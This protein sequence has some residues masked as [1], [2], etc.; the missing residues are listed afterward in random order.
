MHNNGFAFYL[1]GK[2]WD[3]M[4][5]FWIEN[6]SSKKT[7]DSF[8]KVQ[9]GLFERYL[10]RFLSN[11]FLD[12]KSEM[13]AILWGSVYIFEFFY[14]SNIISEKLFLDFI[15]TSKELKGK[16]IGQFMPDL[17]NSNFI[18][19]WEKPDCIS[20]TEFVEENK[21]FQKSITLKYQKFS[22]LRSSISEELSNK[23]LT[24]FEPIKVI[25]PVDFINYI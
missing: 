5:D 17:W 1:S 8:F 10:A 13:I 20:E 23:K 6:N 11:M 21:I 19:Y 18:H 22:R 9:S 12:N 16:V 24:N 7:T 25:S 4:L 15:E 3:K 14:K 2:I